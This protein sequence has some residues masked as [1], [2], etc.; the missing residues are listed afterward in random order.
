MSACSTRRSTPRDLESALVDAEDAESPLNMYDESKSQSEIT[1][2]STDYREFTSSEKRAIKN[3]ILDRHTPSAAL[4]ERSSSLKWLSFP[5]TTTKSP[6]SIQ[7]D[8]ILWLRQ[9]KFQ[10][11]RFPAG[12]LCYRLPV[13]IPKTDCVFLGNARRNEM[14]PYVEVIFE[15]AIVK[16]FLSRCHG[17]KFTK[18]QGSGPLYWIMKARICKDFPKL[19]DIYQ[20]HGFTTYITAV[21]EI[22]NSAR[23]DRYQSRGKDLRG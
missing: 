12:L 13:S 23:N 15:I 16:C 21:S 10:Y 6:A 3:C 14:T 1:T 11:I 17:I 18:L 20:Q 5:I 4:L 9:Y 19:S 7:K 8:L 2:S 22:R